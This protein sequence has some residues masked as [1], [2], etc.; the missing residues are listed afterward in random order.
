MNYGM[1]IRV[2][3]NLLVL[4]SALM[5]PSLLVAMYYRGPDVKAFIISILI[6]LAVGLLASKN[7][8]KNQRI[9]AR[10]GLTIVVLGWILV[11]FFGALPFVL[12]GSIPSVVDAIFETVS[13]LTTTGATIIEDIEALP[14]GILFWR[15][16]THWIG[17]MGILVFTL[18]LLPTLGIGGFE[19]FKAESPGPVM[20]KITPRIKDTA[21]ILYVTYLSISLIQTLLLMLGGMN[22]YYAL[23]HT[24][25]TVGTGGFSPMNDSIGAYDSTYIHIVIS[26]FMILA[27]TNF[28]LYF[29]LYKGRWREVFKDE[30]LRFYLGVLL[31]ATVLIGINLSLTMYDSTGMAF[32]DSLFHSSAILT[33]TGYATANFNEWPAFS[34]AL[35]FLLMF[36]GGMAGST[37]GGMKSIRILVLFKLIKRE[38]AKI[39]HSKAMIPIRIGKKPVSS[40]VIASI[41]SFFALYLFLLGIGTVIISL[42]GIGIESAASAVAASIGNIGPGFGKVGPAET[43]SEF[44]NFSKLF[45][46]F[47]MLLGRLELFTVIAIIAPKAWRNEV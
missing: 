43:F 12:S 15:S 4:E 36:I 3:G 24:F 41:T 44:S 13:G 21:K 14:K 5:V 25:G 8:V 33:T 19:I 30:E 26:V 37:S 29:A 17:G 2:L 45:L 6:T 27:G 32:R 7:S 10:E 31:M 18:A 34:K 39:F 11:A 46:S 9:K 42:E 47:L 20:D 28:S 22:L 16:F 38:V 35:L 40:N 1:V 23:V